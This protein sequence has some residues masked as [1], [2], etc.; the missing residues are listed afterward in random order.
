MGAKAPFLLPF[1]GGEAVMGEWLPVS[2]APGGEDDL[3][4]AEGEVEVADGVEAPDPPFE[5]DPEHQ[6]DAAGEDAPVGERVLLDKHR[7][8]KELREA[9]DGQEHVARG[10][11]ILEEYVWPGHL[12]TEQ[13]EHRGAAPAVAGGV[14]PHHYG[15]ADRSDGDEERECDQKFPHTICI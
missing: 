8:C 13:V 14:D 6:D 7:G 4:E 1:W 15:A 2:Q 11:E 9:V 10:L 12:G 3:Q 5:D